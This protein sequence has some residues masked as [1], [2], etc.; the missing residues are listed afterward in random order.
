MRQFARLYEAL[1]ST[2][3]INRKVAA[4]VD[5]FRT[6]PP[7][8]A[9]WAVYFLTGRRLKRLVTGPAL[10]QW[11][12][13]LVSLPEWLFEESYG[14]V[15]DGAETMALL[16][17]LVASPQPDAEE[18][19]LAAWVEERLLPLRQ[20]MPESQ[21]ARVKAWMS[22]L[23]RTERFML[24]KLLTGEFRVGVSDTLV[25]RA[26]GEVAHLEPAAIAHRLM[27][28]WEP[29]AERFTQVVSAEH[30]RDDES[31]PYPFFL[32]SPLEADPETLGALDEWQVEWK[33]DGIR[34]QLVRRGGNLYLWSRGEDLITTRF[35]EI[36]ASATSLPDGTVLDGE[37]LAWRGDR[38]LPFGDLQ[39]RIGRRKN[40]GQMALA[41]PAIFMA[42]DVLELDGADARST[43]LRERRARL[44]TLLSNRAGGG[45]IR[46]SPLVN[47][48]SWRDLAALREE[49]RDRGV[50]GFMLKH[51]ESAYGTGRRKGPW[52]KWKI[53]PLT[54][55]AVLI[56]AQPGSGKR[57]SLMTDYTF[58]LWEGGELVPVAKA[59]SGLSNEE[60]AELDRWIRANTKERF[61]PV[62]L[63]DPVHVF[64]L[65][66]EG[67][68]RSTRH[69]SGVA[70]RFPR[71]LRWRKDKTP[72]EADTVD[73]L[74]TLIR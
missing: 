56:Y 44:E 40:V 24:A 60:I 45:T 43:P 50:E 72:A 67:V 11:T 31:R 35:P 13:E 21:G 28:D 70:V 49:A 73:A 23:E 18:L 69:K 29:T 59:Y 17:D 2:T 25:V 55:D 52:W 62:R 66:F 27:G 71:M 9:A 32:A 8:D 26:L 37:V 39:Q 61:G 3:S 64:E 14:T 30:T 53:A 20:V 46:L 4:L 74:K 68:F 57:A 51:R 38:P 63:V 34:A 54:I 42:Y 15:G 19:P 12:L 41:A 10:H 33:W 65:G 58:G 22:S 47:A 6:A 7:A 1:D 5:Y 36:A 48:S 16:V